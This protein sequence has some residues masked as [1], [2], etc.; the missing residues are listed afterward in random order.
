MSIIGEMWEGWYDDLERSIP[1]KLNK[2]AEWLELEE[3][4]SIG[5]NMWSSSKWSYWKEP[6]YYTTEQLV[7]KFLKENK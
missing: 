7:K 3:F 5:Y 6:A 1:I 2:F 4:K